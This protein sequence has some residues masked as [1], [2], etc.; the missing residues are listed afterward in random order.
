[1]TAVVLGAGGLLGA[2]LVDELRRAGRA[3]RG[4]DRAACDVTEAGE[5]AAAVAAGTAVVFNCA[6]Y[7]QVDRAE[8]DEDAAYAVNALGAAH[9]AD[10][11]RARGA[12]L[13]QVS[14]DL[15]FDGSL[16]RPYDELDAPAPLSVYGRS[17]WAGERLAAEAGGRVAIVRTQALYGRGGRS[18]GSRL[19]GLLTGG[20]PVLVDGERPVQPTWARALARQ[21]I[22]IADQ[23]ATGILHAACADPTTWAE[24]AAEID[25]SQG[26]GGRWRAV[27]TAA[28]G[29]RA[30]RPRHSRLHG[31]LL[32][33]R[34]LDVLP[35]WRTA[36][37]GFLAELRS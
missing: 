18:F 36:L 20:D 3:V 21:L 7:T 11:A 37:A 19:P 31:R 24:V 9:A 27:P 32:R 17:K 1:V 6:A 14:T 13:V 22:R 30:P 12:L 23:G 10:A 25:R 16:D 34:G 29:L 5:V 8:E 2:H 35:D 33:L 26:G 28:L 15:V 4:V